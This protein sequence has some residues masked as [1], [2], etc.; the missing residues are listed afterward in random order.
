M[1]SRGRALAR[2]AL[3]T[4]LATPLAATATDPDLQRL[5]QVAARD[6]GFEDCATACQRQIDARMAQCPGYREILTPADSSPAAPRCK[7]MAIE[8]F[9]SCMARCPAPRVAAQG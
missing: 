8:Q 4:T 2:L 5:A 1:H 9:E 3:A 7:A 6:G